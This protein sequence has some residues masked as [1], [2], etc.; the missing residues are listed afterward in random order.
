[1]PLYSLIGPLTHWKSLR[2][3]DEVRMHNG[4]AAFTAV[5]T[6]LLFGGRRVARFG[7]IWSWDMVRR[8]VP[9]W[10]VLPVLASEWAAC[11]LADRIEVSVA[12]QAAY[13]KAV[14]GVS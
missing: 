12:S 4:P 14:H 11:R 3:A 8:G 13:L 2:G 10:K 7:F 9:F 1:M 6:H 5:I